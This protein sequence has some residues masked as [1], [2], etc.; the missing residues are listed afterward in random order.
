MRIRYRFDPVAPWHPDPASVHVPLPEFVVLG[1][2]ETDEDAEL[3]EEAAALWLTWRD[4]W[5]SGRNPFCPES[6]VIDFRRA[7]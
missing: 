2:P 3:V 7:A 6:V 5:L 1:E 4:R